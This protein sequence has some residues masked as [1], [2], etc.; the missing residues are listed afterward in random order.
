MGWLSETPSKLNKLETSYAGAAMNPM[1][2]WVRL[3]QKTSQS[4]AGV[5][6]RQFM[7]DNLKGVRRADRG[8]VADGAAVR[9]YLT[10]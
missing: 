2:F 10:R 9:L 6:R 7:T 4:R 3:G 1:Q 8:E 5:A